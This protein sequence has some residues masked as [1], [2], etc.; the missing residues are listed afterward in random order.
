MEECKRAKMYR[1]R[2]LDGPSVGGRRVHAAEA[3]GAPAGRSQSVPGVRVFA[4]DNAKKPKHQ[5][6]MGAS[7]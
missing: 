7:T 3:V 2:F 6:Y 4:S 1:T 5:G